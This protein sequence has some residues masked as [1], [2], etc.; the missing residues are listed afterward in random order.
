MHTGRGP[1]RPGNRAN[2]KHSGLIT[3]QLRTSGA[4]GGPV[5][6]APPS[7]PSADTYRAA[8]P[9]PPPASGPPAQSGHRLLCSGS[10]AGPCSQRDKH[11]RPAVPF[12]LIS[13]MQRACATRPSEVDPG[14][15]LV[16]F[17]DQ[18]DPAG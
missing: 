16:E 2:A 17:S 13:L 9:R 15:M 7:A 12:K 18:Q 3:P 1:A 6:W 5:P 8:R 11:G 14:S 10:V 4:R